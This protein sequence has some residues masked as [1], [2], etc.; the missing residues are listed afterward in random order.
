MPF[1]EKTHRDS[2]KQVYKSVLCDVLA[3]IVKYRTLVYIISILNIGK[4][5]VCGI[6]FYIVDTDSLTTASR[7]IKA[8]LWFKVIYKVSKINV[9]WRNDPE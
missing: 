2:A 1:C 8:Q 7:Q 5:A 4:Q 9:E 6:S 3:L